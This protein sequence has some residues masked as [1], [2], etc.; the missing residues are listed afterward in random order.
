MENR[1]ADKDPCR[2]KLALSFIAGVEWPPGE[3]L[4]VL[5]LP[6]VKNPSIKLFFDLLGVLVLQKD[7]KILLCTFLKEEPGL[8]P[9]PA[10]LSLDCSSLASAS[11]PFP[12]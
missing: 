1:A 2:G 5:L 11:L 3:V 4:V 7:S 9:K 12:D 10:P 8:C 6:R